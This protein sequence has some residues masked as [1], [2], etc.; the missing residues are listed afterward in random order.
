MT[1]LA[2]RDLY[3]NCGPRSWRTLS[4]CVAIPL[5]FI[6]SKALLWWVSSPMPTAHGKP[7]ILMADT[8]KVEGQGI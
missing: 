7:D 5:S 8:R 1:S 2:G 4:I 3:P 6:R